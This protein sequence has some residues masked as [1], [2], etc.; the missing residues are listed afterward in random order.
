MDVPPYLIGGAWRVLD[1]WLSILPGAE[2]I[3]RW[4]RYTTTKVPIYFLSCLEI[5]V[6]N[7]KDLEN[8]KR[9]SVR[10]R[11][12]EAREGGINGNRDGHHHF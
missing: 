6:N 2:E 9:G 10:Q 3:L 7:K 11:K 4:K 1:M 5:V 8:E 12:A